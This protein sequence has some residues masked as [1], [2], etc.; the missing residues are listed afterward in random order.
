MKHEAR[1]IALIDI[2]LYIHSITDKNLCQINPTWLQKTENLVK[3]FWKYNDWFLCES[4]GAPE[5]QNKVYF[6]RFSILLKF[7]THSF[8]SIRSDHPFQSITYLMDGSNIYGDYIWRCINISVWIEW[9]CCKKLY[10]FKIYCCSV[11][12]LK[13]LFY[14]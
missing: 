3:V 7:L 4:D 2:D 8:F 11:T 1:R 13:I 10:C 9:Y 6:R 14:T 12:Q 5:R